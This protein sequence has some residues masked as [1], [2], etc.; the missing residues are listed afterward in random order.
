M[1][2]PIGRD[3]IPATAYDKL[4]IPKIVTKA[5]TVI[6]PMSEEALVKTTDGVK[7][8]AKKKNGKKF[9]TIKK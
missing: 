1:R 2:M 9:K 7:K 6:E 8:F 3:F 5:G 4:T